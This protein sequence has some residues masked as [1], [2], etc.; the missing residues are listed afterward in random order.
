M[1]R[2]AEW[3]P[4]YSFQPQWDQ[5]NR[6]EPYTELFLI[7]AAGAVIRPA[8][9]PRVLRPLLRL[10]LKADRRI[11]LSPKG[12][13]P[14]SI[15]LYQVDKGEITASIC[16]PFDSFCVLG[17]WALAGRLAWVTLV[18]TY[19]EHRRGVRAAT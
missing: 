10:S 4:S 7:E 11:D 13:V 2:V 14:K 6:I 3:C 9:L 16:I 18:L 12:Q 17:P 8:S 15:G 19:P 1:V 5:R